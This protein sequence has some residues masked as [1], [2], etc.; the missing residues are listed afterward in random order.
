VL[1]LCLHSRGHSIPA[2]W[3]AEGLDWLRALVLR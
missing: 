1:S 2:E 3:V